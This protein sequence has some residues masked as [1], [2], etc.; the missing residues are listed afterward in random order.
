MVVLLALNIVGQ[1]ASNLMLNLLIGF[2]VYP[3]YSSENLVH[4]VDIFVAFPLSSTIKISL[5]PGN[6][7]FIIIYSDVRYYMCLEISGQ[8]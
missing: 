2:S 7:T 8:G 1:Y 3:V 6:L 5:N 4:G